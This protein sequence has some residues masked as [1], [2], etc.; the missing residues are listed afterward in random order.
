MTTAIAN[1][2]THISP[3][4]YKL[5]ACACSRVPERLARVRRDCTRFECLMVY[6]ISCF[7]CVC[8]RARA[9]VCDR[10]LERRAYRVCAHHV[11]T[12]VKLVTVRA[13]VRVPYVRPV[14][15]GPGMHLLCKLAGSNTR[16]LSI[17][18]QSNYVNDKCSRALQLRCDVFVMPAAAACV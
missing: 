3:S 4:T 2:R 10:A 1:T 18:V 5:G 12:H 17:L 15:A 11:N 9:R 14:A 13:C 6:R 7:T 16:G 8:V